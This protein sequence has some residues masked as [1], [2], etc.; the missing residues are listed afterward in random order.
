MSNANTALR[1]TREDVHTWKA[2]PFEIYA[3]EAYSLREGCI[4]YEAVRREEPLGEFRTL[5][6]AMAAAQASW[7]ATD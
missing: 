7:D 6:E 1:W 4:V 2:G 5:A 3:L